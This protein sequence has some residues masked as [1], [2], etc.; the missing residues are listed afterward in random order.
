M[1][2]TIIIA[3]KVQFSMASYT[4]SEAAALVSVA[5]QISSAFETVKVNVSTT[6]ETALGKTHVMLLTLYLIT[7]PFTSS[8]W[9]F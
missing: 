2:H 5:V 4:V 7:T 9:C 8:P 6:G 3:V 1:I